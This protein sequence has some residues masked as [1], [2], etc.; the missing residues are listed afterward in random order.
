MSHLQNFF[1][2][3]LLGVLAITASG[4]LYEILRIVYLVEISK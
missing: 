1:V 4:F 2:T 3:V